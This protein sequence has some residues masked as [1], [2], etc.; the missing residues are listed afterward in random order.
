M[1]LQ[2]NLNNKP[3]E[4]VDYFKKYLGSNPVYSFHGP[5][6]P[7]I[8]GCAWTLPESECAE[9]LYINKGRNSFFAIDEKKYAAHS[10]RMFRDYMDKKVSIP[11]LQAQYDEVSHRID[12]VY[13]QMSESDVTNFAE[14]KLVEWV[15]QAHKLLIEVIAKT[16]YIETFD[17]VIAKEILPIE[18]HA[19]LEALWEK[20]T[21]PAFISFDGRRLQY[22]VSQIQNMGK[23][24][25]TVKLSHAI[26]YIHTDYFAAKR[27]GELLVIV[28]NL[29][30]HIDEKISESVQVEKEYQRNLEN[31]NQWFETLSAEQQYIVDYVQ[32][33]M[34]TRDIRKDPIAKTQAIFQVV[35]DEMCTRAGLPI[36]ISYAILPVELE[37][38]ITYL[39]QHAE[40]IL[41]RKDGSVGVINNKQQYQ[42]ACADF[43][44]T[45]AYFNQT[46]E[47]RNL[48][49][50]FKER[51]NGDPLFVFQGP[52]SPL[53]MIVSWQKEIHPLHTLLLIK[54][55]QAH[56]LLSDKEYVAL[57]TDKMRDYFSGKVSIESM[58]AEYDAWADETELIYQDVMRLDVQKLSDTELTDRMVQV[59]K[60]FTDLCK[61]IYIE[62]V[63]YEKILGVIG[64][65]HKNKLDV[66]WERATEAAFISFE[67][68][69]LKKMLDV[70]AS[71]D[72]DTVRLLR[73]IFTD[74]FWTKN[75]VDIETEIQDLKKHFNEK[76]KAYEVYLQNITKK[77][78][79]HIVWLDSLDQYSR[80][81]AEYAQLVMHLRDVRK[82]PIAQIQA[83]LSTIS[84]EMLRRANIDTTLAPL[85]LLYEYMRGI[86]HLVSIKENIEHRKN[87]CLYLAYADQTYEV[88]KCDYNIALHQIEELIK[89]PHTDTP[90][91][92]KGQIA[93][94]GVVRGTVRVVLDPHDDKGFKQGDIL[95]T[96]MTRPEFVPLMKKAGAVVTNEGGITCHAAIVSRELQIPCIIGT[97]VATQVL[98]DGDVV[99][100][101]AEKG[102]VTILEK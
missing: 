29:L 92:L 51:V 17:L 40:D 90:S 75:D 58:Q 36:D 79:E 27:D 20:A 30:Q 8:C 54:D 53:F 74:Y 43:D 95:V 76:Q 93:C 68:R 84:V 102:I 47:P 56:L 86:E 12:T 62:N 91:T 100:V 32:F 55:R 9:I 24:I 4:I 14:D 63:D 5:L 78:Q 6:S 73:F 69:R 18:K 94:R 41:K 13:N 21:H 57:A 77:Y 37:Q 67:Q 2:I 96:S 28:N 19:M 87:G 60:L 72:K 49:T 39:Q 66:I 23:N 26:K 71:G 1:G 15:S 34:K 52:L 10:A 31:F 97:K 98:K 11:D 25:D 38:G 101:D 42:I 35:G 33:V 99:E 61:T 44:T 64:N 88:E 48:I 45:F 80:E 85:V 89:H 16:L 46:K 22:V 81:I 65:N 83:I 82:D 7:L 70:I 50:K 3:A 59:N